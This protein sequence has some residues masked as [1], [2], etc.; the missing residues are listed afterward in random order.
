MSEYSPH[1]RTFKVDLFLQKVS[2]I[3]F[4]IILVIS[5]LGPIIQK[6][7]TN[8]VI[9]EVFEMVIMISIPFY[10]FVD[11]IKSLLYILYN[12]IESYKYFCPKIIYL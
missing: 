8:Y 9:V 10:F 11:S 2:N 1:N 4:W 7:V 5:I 6:I 3:I 12:F